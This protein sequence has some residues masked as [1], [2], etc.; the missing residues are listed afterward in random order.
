M[1]PYNFKKVVLGPLLWIKNRPLSVR[2]TTSLTS[3]SL[4]D[5][6]NDA[7]ILKPFTYFIVNDIKFKLTLNGA[8]SIL[9]SLTQK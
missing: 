6:K 7:L 1:K 9:I 4:S 3:I 8:D 5:T 2:T